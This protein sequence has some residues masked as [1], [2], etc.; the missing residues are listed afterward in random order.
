M[1]PWT[2]LGDGIHVRQ[3]RAF[4]M[5]SVL[6]LHSEHA[7]V[8]DPGILPSELDDLA[9]RVKA[10]GAKAV[11]LVFTHAHWDHVLGKAWWPTAR[12]IAH[13]RFPADLERSMQWIHADADATAAEH[14]ETWAKK[15][16]PFHPK[17]LLSGLRFSKLGPW[18]LVFRDAFGHSDSQMSIHLPEQRTLIAADMLSDIEVPTLN[19]A[20]SVYI[21]TLQTLLP[22]A[23]GNPIETLVPGHGSIARGAEAVAE[24]FRRDLEY[25][26][27]LDRRARELRARG[28]PLERAQQ[29]LEAMDDV[30]RHP[31]FSMKKAHQKNIQLAYQGNAAAAHSGS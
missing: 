9:A 16:E 10:S 30:E 24:R 23:A 5:N 14:G 7:V 12:T 19:T 20:P 13:D 27:T 4:L 31:D 1:T 28:V 22:V 18:R 15:F 25:L 26:E 8:V 2:D 17:E 29:E 21:A 11:T 3:S 6:L